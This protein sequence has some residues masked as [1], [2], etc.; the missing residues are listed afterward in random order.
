MNLQ[1][2][3]SKESN[4]PSIKRKMENFKKL[5]TDSAPE[6]I[7]QVKY[8]RIRTI[9]PIMTTMVLQICW[10]VP[11]A[12]DP[13]RPPPLIPV[14]RIQSD[15][16]VSTNAIVPPTPVLL[17]HPEIPVSASFAPS[18][19]PPL[20][21]RPFNLH[22]NCERSP[23][24]SLALLSSTPPLSSSLAFRVRFILLSPLGYF[25]TCR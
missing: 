17:F 25:D 5:T 7:P 2:P 1:V 21:P 12:E 16:R 3:S 11:L 10:S 18:P 9:T 15:R 6:Q 24:G 20:H 19:A 14:I 13:T 8:P 23:V 22:I 4:R